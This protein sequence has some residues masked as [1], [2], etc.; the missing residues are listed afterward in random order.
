MTSNCF[1]LLSTRLTLR[2]GKSLAFSVTKYKVV[3]YG[4][5]YI[6]I[7]PSY[8][9]PYVWQPIKQINHQKNLA[10]A[11]NFFGRLKVAHRLHF[12]LT[13]KCPVCSPLTFFWD[14]TPI[15]FV[16]FASKPWL[17]SSAC[18]NLRG[19]GLEVH[20]IGIRIRL[21]T[22]ILGS[23]KIRIRPDP[24]SLDPVNRIHY[25]VVVPITVSMHC[26]LSPNVKKV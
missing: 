18:T 24:N 25:H 21:D 3:H 16:V 1:V 14:P 8:S 9:R 4:T 11:L 10:V 19:L 20:R 17:I 26:V 2:I 6:G 23:G 12:K 22:N 13:F 15:Q 7:V 5:I